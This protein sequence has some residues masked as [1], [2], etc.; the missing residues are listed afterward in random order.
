MFPLVQGDE[1]GFQSEARDVGRQ[2]HNIRDEVVQQYGYGHFAARGASS[3]STQE[4][5]I[6]NTLMQCDGE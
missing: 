4:Q 5:F 3:N 1:A 6:S 2:F